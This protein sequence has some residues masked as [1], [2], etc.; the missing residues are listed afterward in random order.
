LR[1]SRMVI[2]SWKLR[3]RQCNAAECD[4]ELMGGGFG[5]A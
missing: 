3:P 4:Y 2:R 1:S 5:N